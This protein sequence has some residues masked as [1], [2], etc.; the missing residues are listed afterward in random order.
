M[1]RTILSLEDSILVAEIVAQCLYRDSFVGHITIGMYEHVFNN[2]SARARRL[3]SCLR[4]QQDLSMSP[5]ISDWLWVRLRE[6]PIKVRRFLVPARVW[7]WTIFFCR[8]CLRS[9]FHLAQSALITK[10]VFERSIAIDFS[11]QTLRS[12]C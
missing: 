11:L 8:L 1:I 5:L 4:K 6:K 9:V 7:N 10:F 2:A 3:P 12:S